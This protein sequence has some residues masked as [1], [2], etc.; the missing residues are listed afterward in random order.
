VRGE[1]ARMEGTAARVLIDRSHSC[2]L[3]ACALVTQMNV[4]RLACS[5]ALQTRGHMACT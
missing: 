2:V 3:R 4:D 1:N 5:L